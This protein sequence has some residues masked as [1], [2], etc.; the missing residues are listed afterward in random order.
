MDFGNKKSEP[1]TQSV[2]EKERSWKNPWS[3]FMSKD[4]KEIAKDIEKAGK[5]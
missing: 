1:E 2:S 5:N 4:K 3:F